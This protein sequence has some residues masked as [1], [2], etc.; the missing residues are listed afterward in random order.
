MSKVFLSRCSLQLGSSMYTSA[1]AAPRQPYSCIFLGPAA[2]EHRK[3]SRERL[4]HAHQPFGAQPILPI[5]D[6]DLTYQ[7]S[8]ISFVYGTPEPRESMDTVHSIL[9]MMTPV[10]R[11]TLRIDFSCFAMLR[12]ERCL[13]G[14]TQTGSSVTTRDDKAMAG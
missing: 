11:I 4:D 6:Q 5:D 12:I 7:E 13:N 3:W 14:T 8:G 10:R 9:R 2:R 1:R